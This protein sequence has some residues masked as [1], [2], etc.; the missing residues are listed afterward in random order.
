MWSVYS[1]GS[2]MVSIWLAWQLTAQV[3]FLYPVWYSLLKIDQTIEQTMPKHLYK[4]EFA[5]TETTEHHRL[6]AEIVASI[7]DRGSGLPDIIFFAPNGEPLGPLLTNSEIIHLQD[8]ANL[9][10]L[11]GW[12]TLVI[13]IICLMSLALIIFFGVPMPSVKRLCIS[14]MT[15]IIVFAVGVLFLGAKKFFYWL[16]TIIFPSDHQ[17]F[18]YYEESLMS[19][20][21]KAPDLFAPISVMLLVIGLLIWLIHLL[22]IRKIAGLKMV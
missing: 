16:H 14:V 4:K 17:W 19:T 7:Q 13:F 22:V 5:L 2:V 21:M 10:D 15:M 20:I 6:F 3:N 9:V 8:V 11:L 12:F 1:L 18:F